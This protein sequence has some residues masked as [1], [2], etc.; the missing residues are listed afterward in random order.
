M[1]LTANLKASSDVE[2]NGEEGSLPQLIEH[3]SVTLEDVITAKICG[4]CYKSLRGLRQLGEEGRGVEGTCCLDK[5]RT[6]VRGLS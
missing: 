5:R 2:V 6:G 4:W 3:L 1:P